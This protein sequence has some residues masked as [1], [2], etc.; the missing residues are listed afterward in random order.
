MKYLNKSFV[1]NTGNN[2]NDCKCFNG[3]KCKNYLI[4]CKECFKIQGKFI[5]FK[6]KQNV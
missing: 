2:K 6:E 5:N 3:E 4:K 1:V